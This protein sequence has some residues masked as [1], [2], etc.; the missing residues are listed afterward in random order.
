MFN[1]RIWQISDWNITPEKMQSIALESGWNFCL[2]QGFHLIVDGREI[3]L[4]ND[5]LKPDSI[6][7]Y[8]EYAVVIVTE[9]V[10]TF[11]GTWLCKGIQIESLT[12]NMGQSPL[13]DLLQPLGNSERDCGKQPVSFTLQMGDQHICED[14]Q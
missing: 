6:H 8:Q 10:E 4:L 3:Y 1:K 13:L 12:V 11:P 2:C 9:K 5:S 14:C 7:Y